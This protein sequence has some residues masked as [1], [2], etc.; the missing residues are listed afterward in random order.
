MIRGWGIEP[1]RHRGTEIGSSGFE[2]LWVFGYL[3]NSSF[4]IFHVFGKYAG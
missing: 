1:L 3:G 4:L 2:F